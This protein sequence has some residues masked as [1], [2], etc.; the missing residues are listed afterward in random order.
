M[1]IGYVKVMLLCNSFRVAQ[2]FANY[3]LRKQKG[4]VIYLSGRDFIRFTGLAVQAERRP[5]GI[6]EGWLVVSGWCK[7]SVAEL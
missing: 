5:F 3:V 6:T 7:E 1:F 2:P 4:A